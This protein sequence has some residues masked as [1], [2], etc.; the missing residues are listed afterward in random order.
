MNNEEKLALFQQFAEWQQHPS[1]D[2]EIHQLDIKTAFLNASLNEE[3]YM[4]QPEGF[5]DKTQPNKVCKLNKALYGLKQS[6]RV[7]CKTLSNKLNSVGYKPL[8]SDPSIFRNRGSYIAAYVD[9]GQI[10][11]A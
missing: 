8:L 2:Y 1:R 7:W 3:V 5:V 4:V 10:G 6:P 9:E 11:A